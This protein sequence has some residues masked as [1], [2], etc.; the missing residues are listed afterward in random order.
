MARP[1]I[2]YVEVVEAINHLLGQNKNPTIEQIRLHLGTGSSTTIANHL[3]KWRNEQTNLSL[4]TTKENIPQELI[5]LIK[6]LWERVID[7]SDIKINAIEENAAQKLTELQQALEKYKKN[8]QRWQHLFDQWQKEKIQLLNEKKLLEQEKS[9]LHKDN[10]AHQIKQEGYIQQLKE[11]QERINELQKLHIQAQNNLEHHRESSR[12][13]RLIEQRQFEQSRLELQSEMKKKNE[14]LSKTQEKI[15]F[16]EQQYQ[17]LQK[18]HA[19]LEKKQLQSLAH[20]EKHQKKITQFEKEKNESDYAKELALKQIQ[21]YQKILTKKT[22]ELANINAE[23]KMLAN[24]FA[25]LKQSN[26][27]QQDQIKLLGQEKW[28]LAQE[29][30]ELKG[31]LMQMQ[32]TEKV[33]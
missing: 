22:D 25:E 15:L 10:A 33:G 23:M 31:Q 28:V 3:K 11:K 1:G 30:A 26:K 4:Q 2:S 32:K 21:D 8:N 20:L 12:T 27:Q 18:T 24:R 17:I 7:Q 16:L 29:R 6:G 13:Q 9:T 5:A 19:Q 14:Q